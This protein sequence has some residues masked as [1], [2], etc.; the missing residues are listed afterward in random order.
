MGTIEPST[1]ILWKS[2]GTA[3]KFSPPYGNFT[4]L[5]D[6]LATSKAVNGARPAA[7][8]RPITNITKDEKGFEFYALGP[9]QWQTCA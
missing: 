5:W 4:N 9:Y 3:G 2:T 1:G 6:T 8:K 7:G